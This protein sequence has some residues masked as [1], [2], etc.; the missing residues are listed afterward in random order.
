M[1][2][3]Y[4]VYSKNVSQFRC[5]PMV[6]IEAEKLVKELDNAFVSYALDDINRALHINTNTTMA[7]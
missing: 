5:N 3:I 2:R 6:N 4:K 1:E 7:V